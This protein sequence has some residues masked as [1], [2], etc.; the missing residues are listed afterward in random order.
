LNP[1]N[2][3]NHINHINPF[4]PINLFP[5]NSSQRFNLQASL[6]L[7]VTRRGDLIAIRPTGGMVR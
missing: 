6:K 4:N 5:S 2:P 7:P 3:I 1:I